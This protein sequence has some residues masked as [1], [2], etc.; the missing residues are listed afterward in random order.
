MKISDLKN[1]KIAILWFWLEWSSTL[2]FLK[3][4][5]VESITVIDKKEP[6][7]DIIMDFK[8]KNISF[9]FWDNYLD[10]LNSFDLIFKTPWISP[11]N[12]PKLFEFKDKLISQLE[13]FSSNY[14]WKI[15]WITWTKGK[16]TI[17]TLIYEILKEIWYNV[18]LVW[19]IWNPV[20][21]EIDILSW[22]KYDFI[23]YELSSYMLEWVSIK[24]FIWLLNNL[25]DCHLDWHDWRSN[26]SNAK[27]NILKNAE[28]RLIS[29][30][31]KNN[32]SILNLENVD[33]FGLEWKYLYKDNAF[34]IWNKKIL[35]DENIALK[36]EHNRKNIAWILWILDKIWVLEKSPI[37]PFKKGDENIN[38]IKKV[39]A[40]FIWLPHRQELV[41]EFHWITF[42]N[43]AIATTPE[44]TMAAIK[45]FWEKIGTIFIWNEDS[46]FDLTE[47][48]ETIKKYN[49]KNIVLF[50]TTWEKLFWD[51][52]KHM[53]FEKEIILDWFWN[54][55]PKIYKTLSME[56]AVLFAYENTNVWEIVLLS[57]WAPSFN[58][59]WT[60]VMPWKWYV[61]KWE[62]FKKYIFEISKKLNI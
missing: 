50:P 23:V 18:K 12:N 62:M 34:Y 57:T 5:W 24:L 35:D 27:F 61:E 7:N 1:K 21:D 42:I 43:D 25:Y 32:K 40:I 10:N 22:E 49:I 38:I 37:I 6:E 58:A 4:I 55:K 2:R 45:T 60:W 54:Y 29:Y 13:I 33:F 31:L 26:Y 20:L 41:W 16:S 59:K 47:L 56:K 51:F 53:E 36:W 3:K 30:E 11:Y 8:N 44:S 52:S 17:S 15:I 39:L 28:N 9:I 48:R 46:G 14:Y 19:N